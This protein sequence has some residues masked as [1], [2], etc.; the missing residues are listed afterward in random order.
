MK[1]VVDIYI[2]RMFVFITLQF[3]VGPL[4]TTFD[5]RFYLSSIEALTLIKINLSSYK[6]A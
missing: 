3:S 5:H 6:Y 2:K 1:R 4:W